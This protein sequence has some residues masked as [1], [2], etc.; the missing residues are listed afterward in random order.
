MNYRVVTITNN[1]EDYPGCK[2]DN[3]EF[4]EMIDYVSDETDLFII[5][6]HDDGTYTWYP[7]DEFFYMK[8]I[9]S[10]ETEE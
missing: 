9:K 5:E 3:E 6:V 10:F 2:D 8:K 1:L 4:P 7:A